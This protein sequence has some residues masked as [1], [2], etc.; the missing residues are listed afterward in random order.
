MSWHDAATGREWR[1]RE[2]LVAEDLAPVE[3]AFVRRKDQGRL[4][5]APSEDAEEKTGFLAAHRQVADLIQDEDLRVG[6]LLQGLGKAM[7]GERAFEPRQQFL[8]GEEE[9]SMP[10]LAGLDA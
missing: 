6:E 5:V 4:L 2:H 8:H 1:W 7:L 10:S 3:E 9:H